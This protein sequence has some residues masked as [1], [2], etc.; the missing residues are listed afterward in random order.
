MIIAFLHD[1]PAFVLRLSEC[2]GREWAHLYPDWNADSARREFENQPGDGTLPL[3][4]VA[5]EGGELLGTV[6]LIVN[7]L[8]RF[9]HFNP[10]L[11]NLFVLPEHRG[12]SVAG[13]LIGAAEERL[14]ALGYP[15]GYLF[16]ESA[17][18]LFEKLGWE[19]VQPA[20]CLGHPVT[21]L[22]RDF[23]N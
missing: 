17:R 20:Q 6:S 21:I 5:L 15:A 13:F 3:T 8:P 9:E 23:Q 14:R 19:F 7:D 4:L 10:W 11:A 2:C 22:R 1:H 16:T 18:P 12:E